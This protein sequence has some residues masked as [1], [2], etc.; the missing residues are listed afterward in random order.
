MGIIRLGKRYGT[1]RVEAAAKR[2][3]ASGAISYKSIKSILSSGLDRMEVGG[4]G[5]ERPPV[6]EH[7]NLRGPGYYN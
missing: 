7:D 1:E 3:L 2:A 4:D 5:E 6:P